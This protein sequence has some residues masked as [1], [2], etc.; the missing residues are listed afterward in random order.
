M[1]TVLNIILPAF[2]KSTVQ[3]SYSYS[4]LTNWENEYYRTYITYQ[5]SYNYWFVGG[6]FESGI[7]ALIHCALKLQL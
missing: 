6:G 2:H 1:P 7:E 3:Y 4:Y 5:K